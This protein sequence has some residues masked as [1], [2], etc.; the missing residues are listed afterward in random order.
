MRDSELM[1]LLKFPMK[2]KRK[3]FFKTKYVTLLKR[4]DIRLSA[5][6]ALGNHFF[7]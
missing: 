2:D 4:R 5:K 7:I 1:D 6:A 3:N